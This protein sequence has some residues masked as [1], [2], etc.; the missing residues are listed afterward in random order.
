MY[1]GGN[2]MKTIK[3]IAGALLAV[4]IFANALPRIDVNAVEYDYGDA[5]AKGILFYEFQKSGDLDESTLRNNWRGDSCLNDGADNGVDLT[6]GWYDA[7][8]H[9]KFNLPMAY[10]STMLAWSYLE[11]KDVYTSTG[12]DVYMLDEIKWANDYFIKC[13]PEKYVYYYQ[14][15]NGGADHAFWGSAEILQMERPS[16]KVTLDSPGAA[17]CAETAA[18]LAA[19]SIIYKDIDKAYSEECLRHAKELLDFAEQ[20]KS[21]SG[22]M[23]QASGFYSSFSGCYDELSWGSIWLYKATGDKAYLDKSKTY[24]DSW[25]KGQDGGFEYKWAHGWDDVHIGTCLLITELTGEEKYKS[26]LEK[27]LD[28]WTTGV[29]GERITYTPKGL[30]WLDSWGSLRYSATTSFIASVY[31]DSDECSK[32]NSKKYSDFAQSQAEYMLGSTGRSFVIGYGENYPQ[33]PHHRTAHGA[34]ENNCSG[35]P[36]ESRHVLVGALVG[37]PDANDNYTD[38]ISDYV[39]NEVACDYNA[40]FVGL[41]AKMYEDHGGTKKPQVDAFEPV[42]DE[43]WIEAGI[44]AQDS[45]NTINFVEIKAVV[46]NRSAW[47]ARVSDK[48]TY[49]FFVDISDVIAQGYSAA[50]MTV[51]ANYSQHNAKSSAL[52]PFD[53][54]KGIY[55]AEIDMTGAL[56]YPGGQSEHKSELQFRVAAPCKWNYMASPSMKGLEASS[57]NGLIRAEGFALYDNGT[58]IFGSDPAGNVP[59]LEN[60]KPTVPR[61]GNNNSDKQNNQGNDTNNS[62]TEGG[63]SAS[64][65]ENRENGGNTSSDNN[66]DDT[67]INTNTNADGTSKQTGILIPIAVVMLGFTVMFL[68]AKHNKT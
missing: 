21:D 26:T 64:G 17:V 52:Q 23:Q 19:C 61:T 24:S 15:G 48:L 42:G 41:M 12:Q 16:Y 18:S 34:Y 20:N 62:R 40:G 37:G 50:D 11:S 58:M 43:I 56:L 13:H 3:R 6:G 4:G 65:N 47:P 57:P 31:A 39:S 68:S 29:N 27:H 14:V 59:D 7:G 53:E 36:A 22:Y 63:N 35:A 2:K 67:V 46:Y 28:Y 38:S 8:D 66:D 44:N 33:H 51:S 30:A 45:Q 55:F 1:F 10:T 60:Y 49:R 5:L 32:A 9:V 25:N 54:A